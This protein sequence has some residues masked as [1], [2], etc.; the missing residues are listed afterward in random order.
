MLVLQQ[1][2]ICSSFKEKMEKRHGVILVDGTTSC[3]EFN[4]PIWV[5]QIKIA[6]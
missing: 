2:N 5:Y 3:I 6:P 4:A 1:A